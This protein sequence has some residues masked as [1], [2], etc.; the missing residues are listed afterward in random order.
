M[1]RQ[2]ELLSAGLIQST[3]NM[4]KQR[5]IIKAEKNLIKFDCWKKWLKEEPR[6]L[7]ENIDV[8]YMNYK[9]YCI[10]NNYEHFS[11]IDFETVLRNILSVK[12]GH[13]NHNKVFMKYKNK[14]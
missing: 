7:G 13:Y 10:N 5:N 9:I 6:I 3:T 12:I 8:S 1:E 2:Q 11:Q 4:N 14:K